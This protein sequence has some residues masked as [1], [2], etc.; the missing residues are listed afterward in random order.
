[1][2]PQAPV[3]PTPAPDAQPPLPQAK[4]LAPKV[5]GI[6]HLV[7]GVMGLLGSL[8]SIAMLKV[9]LGRL[10]LADLDGPG[11]AWIKISAFIG[12]L[13]GILLIVAGIGL[14]SYKRYGRTLSIAYGFLGLLLG[15]T[16][17]IMTFTV[18]MP[19]MMGVPGIGGVDP[20]QAQAEMMVKIMGL[21][22]GLMRMIYPLVLVIFFLRPKSKAGLN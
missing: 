14:L 15:V 8:F 22:V 18:I 10:A 5:F 4:P 13:P 12:P 1:M 6:I 2:D 7:L 21:I 11:L 3:E 17:L 19:G 9:S 20:G 16:D